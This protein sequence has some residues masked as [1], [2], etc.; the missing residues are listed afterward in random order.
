VYQGYAQ[1]AQPSIPL[2]PIPPATPVPGKGDL[3]ERCDSIGQKDLVMRGPL[4]N[5]YTALHG[6]LCDPQEVFSAAPLTG[7]DS[8]KCLPMSPAN[9]NSVKLKKSSFLWKVST[10]RR[11]FL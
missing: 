6:L 11:R 5:H 3:A 10:S 2:A 8:R 9:T 1:G 4:V 7:K